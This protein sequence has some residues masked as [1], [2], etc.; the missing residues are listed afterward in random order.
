MASSTSSFVV[1]RYFNWGG[2]A[3]PVLPYEE[4]SSYFGIILK[5]KKE[6]VNTQSCLPRPL[7]LYGRDRSPEFIVSGANDLYE[8]HTQ[9]IIF[10]Y[11]ILVS[12]SYVA[13]HVREYFCTQAHYHDDYE[14]CV[15]IMNVDN[16]LHNQFETYRRRRY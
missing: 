13:K 14:I 12:W 1:E 2:V 7:V 3:Y 8:C 16:K 6:F 4:L 11:P 5:V 10:R 9:R 15:P